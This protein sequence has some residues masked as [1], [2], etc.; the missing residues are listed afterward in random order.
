MGL[1][2][3]KVD[4]DVKIVRRLILERKI[5]PFYKGLGDEDDDVELVLNDKFKAL[6][7]SSSK[8]PSRSNTIHTL[9]PSVSIGSL[10]KRIGTQSTK[11]LDRR[12]EDI[13]LDY[14]EIYKEP[15]ECPIC[16]LYYPQNINY[17]RCCLQPICTECFVQIKRPE[18]TM[19]P[20][21][22]P[23]CVEPSFGITYNQT[24]FRSN[25][26]NNNNNDNDIKE[27]TVEQT[28]DDKQ[29]KITKVIEKVERKSKS[30]KDDGVVS[31]DDIRPDWYQKYED[32][33]ISQATGRSRRWNELNSG[34][35]RT[36]QNHFLTTSRRGQSGTDEVTEVALAAALMAENLNNSPPS[37]SSI[38]G[39][40]AMTI[41]VPNSA[42]FDV[43]RNAGSDLE[44]LMI[45]E[46]VRRS[47]RE[48]E[49][50]HDQPST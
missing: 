4:Y 20:A 12:K 25:N 7:T 2:P 36:Q 33:M 44:D 35:R 18:S 47:L 8:P 21:S 10:K 28:E 45:M 24:E 32:L 38:R 22:C 29:E 31:I 46:A 50:T 42:Y 11:S 23:Y 40:R 19:E 49:S 41:S 48:S 27:E 3:G 26:T 16:F 5:A 37:E 43:M 14:R 17:T 6:S 30:I 34:P 39:R 9:P 1:Y 13:H 15:I